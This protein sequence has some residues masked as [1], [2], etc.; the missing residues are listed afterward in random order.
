MAMRLMAVVMSAAMTV[1]GAA[2]NQAT[3]EEDALGEGASALMADEE[4]GDVAG[5]G[6]V[7]ADAEATVDE[8][9]AADET[10]PESQFCDFQARK[11][12]VLEKYDANGDGKLNRTEAQALRADLGQGRHPR[13]AAAAARIRHH[14]FLRIRWA[15]DED[16]D[17]ELSDLE[18]ANLIAAME[19]RCE[20][21]RK[22][23]L[24]KF[25]ADKDGALS[26]TEREA[27]RA[28][29][30]AKFQ[31]HRASILAQYDAN[32]NGKLDDGERLQLRADRLAALKAR[33]Q[34]LVAKYDTDSD[35]KLSVAEALPLKEAIQQRIAGGQDAE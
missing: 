9:V 5:D 26:E 11:Q 20:R 25:D 33:R 29:V 22:N 3:S 2:C 35:G 27:A 7:D 10:A 32:K 16:G 12:A 31:A 23:V 34:A 30:Q 4:T 28:A 6:V 13:L 18:R 1:A 14:A 24:D 19:A 8:E 17:K 15:F 21:I